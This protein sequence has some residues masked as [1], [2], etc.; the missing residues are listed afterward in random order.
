MREVRAKS[1][2]QTSRFLERVEAGLAEAG[3]DAGELRLVS[4]RDAAVRG[5]QISFAHQ[6]G[7]AIVQALIAGGVIGDFRAPDLMR[8][9]FSPLYLSFAEIDRAADALV[10]ILVTRSWDQPRFTERR[11]VT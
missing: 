8:F 4:P 10:Q 11:V 6:N 2:A 5:G 1:M 3:I 9:G 7:Y